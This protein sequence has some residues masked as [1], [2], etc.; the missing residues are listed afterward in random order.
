MSH[1]AKSK[2]AQ[3]ISWKISPKKY[4][5][6]LTKKKTFLSAGVNGGW[7]GWG[8]WGVCSVTCGAG[9]QEHTRTCTNPPPSNGGAQCSGPSK[10]TRPCNKGPCP[11][12]SLNGT[13]RCL[14]NVSLVMDSIVRRLLSFLGYL[15]APSW[16]SVCKMQTHGLKEM[17]SQFP[18]VINVIYIVM[19]TSTV[20]IYYTD[21]Y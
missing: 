15:K 8:D 3:F 13:D 21:I 11:G 5:C 19:A 9:Q 7:S 1:Y 12:K 17:S 20:I 18:R 2:L 4:F 16:C 6:Q 10:E 14:Q